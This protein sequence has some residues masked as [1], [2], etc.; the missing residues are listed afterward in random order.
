PPWDTPPAARRHGERSRN[1]APGGLFP[2]GACRARPPRRGAALVDED[3]LSAD[4]RARL[5]LRRPPDPL[6]LVVSVVLLL[7]RAPGNP[8]GAVPLAPVLPVLI[9]G[10]VAGLL[11]DLL[12]VFGQAVADTLPEILN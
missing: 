10:A 12:G 4:V 6:P 9:P 3:V 1:T 5:V 8:V 7:D 2:P 11:I